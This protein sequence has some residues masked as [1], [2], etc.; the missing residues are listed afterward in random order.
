[1]PRIAPIERFSATTRQHAILLWIED[2]H[3]VATNMKRTLARSPVALQAL[4][5]WYPLKDEVL[6]FLGER[7]VTLFCHAIST[8]N[9]CLLCSSYFRR[10]LIEAGEDPAALVLDEP[11]SAVVDYGAAMVAQPKD[12]DNEIWTRLEA[13]HTDAQLVTLTVFGTLMIATNI[14]NNALRIDLDS[15]LKPY[16]T[17]EALTG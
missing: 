11:L 14:F 3:G 15:S 2:N 6:K 9:A 17:A 12:I 7:G 13:A 4:L 8:G 10:E 5:Q 1:M 16:H